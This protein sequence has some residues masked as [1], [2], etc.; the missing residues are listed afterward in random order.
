MAHRIGVKEQLNTCSTHLAYIWGRVRSR[1]SFWTHYGVIL[2]AVWTIFGVIGVHWG[3]FWIM[4]GCHFEVIID[5]WR[6]PGPSKALCNV[7]CSSLEPLWDPFWAH[8]ETLRRHSAPPRSNNMVISKGSIR[9]C[10]I[11]PKFASRLGAV[12]ILEHCRLPGATSAPPRRHRE[13]GLH[14]RMP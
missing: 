2:N 3:A 8:L 6:A 5:S 11:W 9:K 13:H 4:L 7:F 10:C 14:G 1:G 12:L